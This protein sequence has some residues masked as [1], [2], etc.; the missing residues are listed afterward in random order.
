MPCSWLCVTS[1]HQAVQRALRSQLQRAGDVRKSRVETWAR[2][3]TVLSKRWITDSLLPS[4]WRA[5][6]QTGTTASQ[7]DPTTPLYPSLL[8][9]TDSVVLTTMRRSFTSENHN[10][11]YSIKARLCLP[12]QE[13]TMLQEHFVMLHFCGATFGSKVTQVDFNCGSISRTNIQ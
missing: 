3:E 4:R 5:G 7:L 11:K 1:S 9:P 2:E 10:M 12:R 8:W 6:S 13:S